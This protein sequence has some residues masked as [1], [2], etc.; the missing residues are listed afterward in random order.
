L[1]GVHALG[2][3]RKALHRM[4]AARNNSTMT[5]QSASEQDFRARLCAAGLEGLSP[6]DLAWLRA[7]YDKAR[8]FRLPPGCPVTTIPA[9]VFE[10]PCRPAH[11]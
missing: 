4:H 5:E 9:P 3:R 11:D 1:A 10:P 6:A 8:A 2:Y 7:A